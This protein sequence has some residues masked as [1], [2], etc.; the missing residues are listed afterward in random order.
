MNKLMIFQVHTKVQT[1]GLVMLSRKNIPLLVNV[2]L[3]TGT[4]PGYTEST[5]FHRYFISRQTLTISFPAIS[6]RDLKIY[7]K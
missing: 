1:S 7:L 3:N 4:E 6:F 2:Y 5:Y